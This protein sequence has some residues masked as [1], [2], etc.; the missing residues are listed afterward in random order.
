MTRT[1]G[2]RTGRYFGMRCNPLMMNLGTWLE[3]E[4]LTYPSGS[5]IRRAKAINI[6]TGKPRIV[7]CGIPDTFFSIPVR[8]GGW[9]DVS[10]G[11]I[12]RFHPPLKSP[13]VS[14]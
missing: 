14:R 8:G 5:M 10:H 9:L 11:G 4:E 2:P 3:A 7:R 13:E 6:E 1:A 12:L